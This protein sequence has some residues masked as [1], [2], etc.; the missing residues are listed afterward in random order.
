MVRLSGLTNSKDK[1][2][3]QES[4]A[5]R[6]NS[7]FDK[8]GFPIGQSSTSAEQPDSRML[9]Q[10]LTTKQ[11]TELRMKES[12][13]DLLNSRRCGTQ[14]NH[15][16]SGQHSSGI[17]KFTPEGEKAKYNFILSNKYVGKDYLAKMMKKE[18]L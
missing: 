10:K 12:S 3:L 8:S 13:E 6:D 18:V 17:L 11:H 16:H 9:T 2:I 7:G 14:V 5:K 1:S 15:L 4:I